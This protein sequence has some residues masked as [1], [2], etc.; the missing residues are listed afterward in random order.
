VIDFS[1]KIKTLSTF[2]NYARFNYNIG[3][4]RGAGRPLSE[5]E[6]VEKLHGDPT[7]GPHPK[8]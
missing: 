6:M 1:A 3:L 7:V 5:N 4:D 8:I 2:H